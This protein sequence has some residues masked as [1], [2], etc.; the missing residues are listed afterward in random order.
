MLS[1]LA[2]AAA[3]AAPAQATEIEHTA[4]LN[5]FAV[6]WPAVDG[7]Y[8]TKLAD[9]Q[10]AYGM[11]TAGKYNPLLLRL[12]NTLLTAASDDQ[13]SI[14]ANVYGVGGGYNYYFKGYENGWYAGGNGRFSRTAVTL[15]LG[16]S[17]STIAANALSLVPVVG[18]KRTWKSGFTMQS[19]IGYGYTMILGGVKTTGDDISTDASTSGTEG[20]TGLSLSFLLG[21]SY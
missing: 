2:L 10:G 14:D 21:Y 16:N 3:L 19:E 7:R 18:N 20:G 6:F 4:L 8:E 5:P 11:V 1:T 9:N 17:S 12:L 13:V 15:E